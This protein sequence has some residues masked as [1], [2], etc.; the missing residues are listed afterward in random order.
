MLT[1]LEWSKIE[2]FLWFRKQEQHTLLFQ[3]IKTD[4]MILSIYAQKS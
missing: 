3:A 4:Q 2:L 1:A